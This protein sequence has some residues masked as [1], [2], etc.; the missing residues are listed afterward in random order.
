MV[1]ATLLLALDGAVRA[2]ADV[3]CI[4]AC[5][6]SCESLDDRGLGNLPGGDESELVRGVRACRELLCP[7]RDMVG[8]AEKVEEAGVDAEESESSSSS[9]GRRASF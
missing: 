8:G 5:I 3:A 7:E 6:V 4:V 1:L 2:E 9:L